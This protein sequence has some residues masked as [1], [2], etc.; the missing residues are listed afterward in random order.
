MPKSW[1]PKRIAWLSN[2]HFVQDAPPE[3]KPQVPPLRYA[4]VGMTILLL[5]KGP[6]SG[7]T[8]GC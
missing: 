4:P 7:Q 6:K 2:L 1:M 5:G 8:D 3:E